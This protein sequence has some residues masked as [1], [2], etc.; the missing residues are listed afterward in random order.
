MTSLD[1]KTNSTPVQIVDCTISQGSF[2]VH[3]HLMKNQAVNI[4]RGLARA[5]IQHVQV[6]HGRG[7]GAK[8]AG[9][10]AL[11]NDEEVLAAVNQAC[12][13][14]TY[15]VFLAPYSYSLEV[16]EDLTKYFQIGRV[17]VN[18][19]E[20][21][22]VEP[23]FK[24]LTELKKIAAGQIMRAHSFSP[25][26]VAEAARQLVDFGA[27]SIWITDSYGSMGPDEIRTYLKTI[28]NSVKVPLGV[29]ARNNTSRAME[30]ALA[31][32]QEG[33]Q[34]IDASLF[35]MGEGAGITPLEVLVSHLH[36]QGLGTA[37]Q[38]QGLC[39]A[40][41]FYALPALKTLPHITLSD[42]LFAKYKMD[43]SPAILMQRISE[44]LEVSQEE[45]LLQMKKL[46]PDM[47]QIRE[48][49]LR[50]YLQKEKL[51]FDVVME[52]IRTGEIPQ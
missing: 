29:Q 5:G 17:G 14:L 23:H 33:V 21:K 1:K 26:Q 31:A 42:L 34:Y 19:D 24:Q 35:G 41:Q 15:T 39:E 20:I 38:L 30:L 22:K 4:V 40:A 32:L 47:V 18:V 27:Q 36:R 52:F 46:F 16:I 44:I 7:I 13:E 50:E 51:D 12:P 37:F 9:Y 6:S 25:Q 49:Q 43:Y 48:E 3:H 45:L 2:Q 8:K 11:H 28:R 10:P